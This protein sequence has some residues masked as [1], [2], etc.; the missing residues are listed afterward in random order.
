MIK[1]I[2]RISLLLFWFS[3]LSQNQISDILN[4]EEN[5]EK[6]LIENEKIAFVDVGSGENTLLFIHGLSSNLQSWNKNISRLKNEYRCI[7]IDLPGYGKSTKNSTTYSLKDYADFLNSFIEKKNLHDVV[8]VG[9]SMGGQVA[10]HTLLA[11]QDN[12]KSLVLIA[13]AGIETFSENEAALMKASYTAEMVEKSTPEQIRNNFKMNF[14]QF[15]EDAEFM[16]RERIEMKNADDMKI[17]SEVVV[18]NIHAMLEEPIIGRL[19]DIE[20]PVLM[21]YGKDDL[22]IPNT[23]FHPSQDIASL[24]KTAKENIRN[25]KV[26]LINEAG[27]FVN[28]EKSKQVN[29]LI[30]EF[31]N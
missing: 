29:A 11:A 16:V 12:F 23:F 31:L 10:V 14:H 17:Y 3:A 15:P 1:R 30:T 6:I 4:Y 18:N 28:F 24:V 22:L 20:I 26:E 13:P 19:S 8:L 5:A 21:I 7:A 27:H 9:H 2:F 25:L